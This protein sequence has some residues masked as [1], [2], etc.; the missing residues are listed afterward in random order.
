MNELMPQM[1]QNLQT[2]KELLAASDSQSYPELTDEQIDAV[3]E[4][5]TLDS[6]VLA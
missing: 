6:I 4:K 1:K 3:G 2:A 5:Y